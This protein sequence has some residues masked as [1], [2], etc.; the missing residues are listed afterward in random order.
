[1]AHL[2]WD[3]NGTLLDDLELVVAATNASLATVGGPIVTA[4]EHRRDF[5]RPVQAYYAD[6]LARAL[7][8][9][10]FAT[11]DRAFHDAYDLGL[12][13]VRLSSGA[14]GALRSWVGIS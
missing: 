13:A 8:P 7:R 1:M 10:E 2:V 5:R 6:V 12:S 11:L 4:D 14:L 3:W 9:G